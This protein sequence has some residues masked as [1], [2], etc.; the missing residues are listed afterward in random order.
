MKNCCEEKETELHALRERQGRVLKVVLLIN[1][2]MFV[3]EFSGGIINQSTALLGDSLDMFGDATV[4]AFSLYVLHRTAR[5]RATVALLKGIVMAAFG[6]W[7]LAEAAV[8]VSQDVTP[9]AQ[10][11]G[12]IGFL[13]LVANTICLL[14]LLRHRADDINMS[15][16]WLC[17]RNDIIANGG[18]LLA[19]GAVAVTAS[20]WPDIIVGCAIALMFLSSAVSVMK[21]SRVALKVS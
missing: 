14:L 10:G 4:Y 17:S 21:E 13:A 7:V 9:T 19:A 3:V 16:T 12:A 2:V 18:V 20:K 1:A 15:S 6:V 11:M 8:K 5:W